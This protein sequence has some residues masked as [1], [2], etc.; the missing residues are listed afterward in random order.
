MGPP[1]DAD[2]DGDAELRGSD[3]FLPLE[4]L[5]SIQN[6]GEGH[7]GGVGLEF[8]KGFTEASFR[9]PVAMPDGEYVMTD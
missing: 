7:D 8:I 4:L 1:K 9:T 5:A 2:G 6:R 3:E